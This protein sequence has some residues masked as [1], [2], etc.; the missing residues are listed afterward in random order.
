MRSE[1]RTEDF[2]SPPD[3]SHGSPRGSKSSPSDSD[4][5]PSLTTVSTC[6]PESPD[7]LPSVPFGSVIATLTRV[8]R[9]PPCRLNYRFYGSLWVPNGGCSQSMSINSRL[10]NTQSLWE[11]KALPTSP[12]G[13]ERSPITSGRRFPSHRLK[14]P[15]AVSSPFAWA[16]VGCRWAGVSRAGC[17]FR[18]IGGIVR[19]WSDRGRFTDRSWIDRGQ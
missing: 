1:R 10:A 4:S 5:H 15:S 8:Y 16:I 6:T 2:V 11:G 19:S 13:G 3:R 12:V 9:F 17:L 14:E 18:P 7:G